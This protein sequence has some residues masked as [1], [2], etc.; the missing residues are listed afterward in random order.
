[1][2][3]SHISVLL[4]ESIEALAIKPDGVYVDGT[5]GGAGHS[6]QIAQRLVNGRLVAIDKDP[7]AVITASQRLA[8]Y[9]TAQVVRADFS[10]AKGALAELGIQQIDGMLLD[11][12]VSSYQLDTPQRGFSYRQDGP[13]DMRMSAQGVSAQEL[14]NTYSAEA[15]ARILWEYGEERF[16][17][18]IAQAIVH[19]REQQPITTTFGLVDVIKSAMPA[20]AMRAGHPARRTFQAIRIAVNGELELLGA[21]LDDAFDLLTPGGRLCVIT[22]HSLEDR[23]V[24]Q[25]FAALCR[26]CTCPPEFPVCICGKTPKGR[27]VY[28][29]PVVPSEEEV[30]QNQRSRSAKL[31]VIERLGAV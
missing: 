3:F 13:L 24:K 20:A 25:R 1:M 4:H 29:K 10:E 30:A 22:F 6:V 7:D 28:K 8:P 5:A 11:L 27:L 21:A 18:R 17:R 26:G 14:V 19:I 2:D 12:G 23:I 16:S 31:R 9:P 15:I